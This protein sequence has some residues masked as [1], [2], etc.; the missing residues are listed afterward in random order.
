MGC[1]V[2][3]SILLA[4]FWV[5][6][7]GLGLTSL[8]I[9]WGRRLSG[10]EVP[11]A[12]YLRHCLSLSRKIPEYYMKLDQGHFHVMLF[13]NHYALPAGHFILYS[14]CYWQIIAIN[15]KHM[16][17]FL[18]KLPVILPLIFYVRANRQKQCL[19]KCFGREYKF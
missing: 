16:R 18:S 9:I 5:P 14:L 3:A 8:I 7:R 12:W 13:P 10:C 17:H 6:L 4:T 2:L 19:G 15:S 1:F 11:P